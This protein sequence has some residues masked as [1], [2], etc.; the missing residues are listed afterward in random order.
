M[1]YLLDTSV[2]IAL[3]DNLLPIIERLPELSGT[4]FLSI[5]TRVELING[6][7]H[8]PDLTASRL[9]R[10]NDMLPSFV[11]LDFDQACIE[12]YE[13]I[14]QAVEFSRRKIL[15]RMIAAQ[16]MVVGAA[17]ITLNPDD[18]RDIAGLQLLHWS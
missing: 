16:A 13:I 17:L 9:A 1:A 4:L 2:A 10:V 5:I 14:I 15:D 11:V 18:F 12:Q 6:I 7:Y 3:R 8:K